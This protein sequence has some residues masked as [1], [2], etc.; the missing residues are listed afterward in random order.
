VI[1][2]EDEQCFQ[3][4]I[5][6]FHDPKG[7]GL[8]KPE[9]IFSI[10]G[11]TKSFTL[12][13]RSKKAFKKGLVKAT[14]NVECW[15]LTNGYCS[16]ISKLVGEAVAENSYGAK[17]TVIGIVSKSVISYNESLEVFNKKIYFFNENIK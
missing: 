6:L 16:G 2:K 3:S 11:A 1:V 5:D 17:V 15:I 14:K 9:V 10:T 13:N 4:L 8:K 7:W 12:N